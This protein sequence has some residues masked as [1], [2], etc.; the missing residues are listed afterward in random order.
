M[1]KLQAEA[2]KKLEEEAPELPPTPIPESVK[3]ANAGLDSEAVAEA[4]KLAEA[5]VGGKEM[6]LGAKIG[7]SL[8]A[9]VVLGVVF[10]VFLAPLISG[11]IGIAILGL[12]VGGILKLMGF[13]GGDDEDGE[14]DAPPP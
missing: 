7:W 3:A 1:Q 12:I 4:A 8:A 5:A 2:R 6:S 9:V 14:E 13:F 11:L 10:N